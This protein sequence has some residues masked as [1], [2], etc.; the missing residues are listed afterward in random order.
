MSALQHTEPRCFLPAIAK[1]PSRRQSTLR[2]L[3]Q[4]LRRMLQRVPASPDWS[5]PNPLLSP[6]IL[7]L[8]SDEDLEQLMELNIIASGGAA[9]T[10]NFEPF[11]G[12]GLLLLSDLD[13]RR[14]DR[15]YVW[16]RKNTESGSWRLAD[17]V[18]VNQGERVLDL[19]CGSGLN[20]L[21]LAMRGAISTG[22]D[23]NPRAIALADIN[24]LLNGLTC[25]T[26][27]HRGW[28]DLSP[29]PYD[30]VI[31]QPPFDPVLPNSNPAYAFG[32]GREFGLE[33]T[34]TILRKFQPR[35]D[36]R[37]LHLYVH[38]FLS[39]AWALLE[40][41]IEKNVDSRSNI[42]LTM[43]KRY[44]FDAWW[45]KYRDRHGLTGAHDVPNSWRRFN[46]VGAFFLRISYR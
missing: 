45:A 3:G 40:R 29:E 12:N 18:V 27:M 13:S 14:F 23:I 34:G 31:S 21:R 46:G 30:L 26:F 20:A 25:S 16:V 17:S 42:S 8:L 5:Q 36:G 39:D 9:L 24:A 6:Q 32:G 2:G 4:A 19:G 22:I 11:A 38:S 7:D 10:W 1:P 37:R 28:D 33:F 44:D 15:E 35:A 43:L 41:C